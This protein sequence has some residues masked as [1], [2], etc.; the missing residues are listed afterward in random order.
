MTS[1]GRNFKTNADV[2]PPPPPTGSSLCVAIPVD[3]CSTSNTRFDR[4]ISTSYALPRTIGDYENSILLSN[5]DD[6]LEK[7]SNKNKALWKK[8]R[9]SL[10]EKGIIYTKIKDPPLKADEKHISNDMI[11]AL[12]QTRRSGILESFHIVTKEREYVLRAKSNEVMTNWIFELQ[13][14]VARAIISQ[15]SGEELYSNSNIYNTPTMSPR[16]ISGGF[17]LPHKPH[18]PFHVGQRSPGALSNM[19]CDE[20]DSD[21]ENF[22]LDRRSSCSSNGDM[23]L[24][25]EL[26]LDDEERRTF[27]GACVHAEQ[28]DRKSMEDRHLVIENLSS[29]AEEHHWPPNNRA[30]CSRHHPHQL[31]AV[32]DGHQGYRAAEFMAREFP[33]ALVQTKAFDRDPKS[34]ITDC[35]EKLDKEFVRKAEQEG[36]NDG[37]TALV[38]IRRGGRIFWGH[39][40]D[41]RAVVGTL[42]RGSFTATQLNQ[43]HHCGKAE[44]AERVK[45]AGGW[46]TEEQDWIVDRFPRLFADDPDM[47]G[48][49]SLGN[50]WK[51][52]YRLNEELAV[53]RAI[54][55]KV[56]K[57]KANMESYD[58][59]YPPDGSH[60]GTFSADLIISVPEVGEHILPES[61]SGDRMFMIMACDGLWDVVT[62]ELAVSYVRRILSQ[63]GSFEN[64][65]EKLVKLALKLGSLDNV[66]VIVVPLLTNV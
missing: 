64:C 45:A 14:F 26:E 21:F 7:R 23:G 9:F 65:S 3:E 28:G 11:K 2:T 34:A 27:E 62:N 50:H 39:I 33:L 61:F 59:L 54:G 51:T 13:K 66:S 10:S 40:G 1:Q 30:L 31:F 55:D 53:S 24:T 16:G 20:M 6:E 48:V 63:D 18:S 4:A 57:G 38:A 60:P 49:T 37:C 36:W 58:W 22:R 17:G 15:I 25:F 44:E 5:L 35:F 42:E 46:I 12:K 52:T 56:F 41:C 29:Y 32:F 43:E 47:Q 19:L 8:C